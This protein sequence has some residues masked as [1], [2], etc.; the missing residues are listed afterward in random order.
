MSK[1]IRMTQAMKA[2]IM[3]DVAKKLDSMVLFD[4]KQSLPIDYHYTGDDHATIVFSRMAWE[5]QVRLVDEFSSEIGWHGMVHRDSDDPSKF[6]IDDL[7]VFPQEV[8]GATVTPE[9]G[10]YD[11]W[12]AMLPP[13]QRNVMR[14][15]GHSHVRMGTTP[16][17]T[18]NTFQKDI[19]G[20]LNG[21]GYT[22][23]VRQ[24]MMEE[25]GDSA[26]Y[27]FMIWNKMR[28]FNVRI[29]DL[30]NNVYY[31]GKEVSVAVDGMENLDD[32]IADAKAK[33]KTRTYQT[34]YYGTD[35]SGYGAN[36]W[37]G[38]GYQ[39]QNTDTKKSNV[40][41]LPAAKDK[42]PALPAI[43]SGTRGSMKDEDHYAFQSGYFNGQET[44]YD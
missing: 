8:T 15:H 5:K 38:Y 16:S 26:F 24:R 7:L 43:P 35:R 13:E 25:L 27:I 39:K 20:R 9:Q 11:R 40:V 30:Y 17:S 36:Y 34:G 14:Y 23:A 31:E 41:D 19:L 33:V 10:E 18:D 22:E 42:K 2:E 4:G 28:E 37:N 32:F 44:I 29:Y 1:P 12:N 21:D 6:Y 3:A